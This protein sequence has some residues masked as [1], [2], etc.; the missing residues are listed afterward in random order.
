MAMLREADDADLL[1]TY[2][3]V[4]Q[5][6]PF[7]TRRRIV[8]I[9]TVG[10]L[11]F[12]AAHSNDRADFFWDDTTRLAAEWTSSRRVLIATN[13]ELIPEVIAALPAPVPRLVADDGKRVVLANFH[14]TSTRGGPPLG[15][16]TKL[17]ALP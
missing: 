11:G 5:G 6:L 13:R 3:K 1:V 9:G 4:M 15:R 10:E 7:Y 12:G 14:S 8:E 17:A 2:R 16:A